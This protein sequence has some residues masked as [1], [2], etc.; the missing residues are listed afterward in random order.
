M[1][2]ALPCIAILGRLGTPQLACLRSWR[3]QGLRCVFLHAD[4]APLPRL[5]QALLGVPCVHLGPLRLDDPAW[6]ARLSAALAQAGVQALTC[7]AEPVSEALWACRAA[8]PAGLRIVSVQPRQAE[9]LAS[10]WRQHGLARAAG[11]QTLAGWY[12]RPQEPVRLPADAFP[13]VVRPDVA[14]R[15]APAFKV[16]VVQDSAALQ[17]LVDGLGPVSEGVVV[18]PLVHGPN[19]LVH[20][21]RSAD[22]RC[23]GHVA[24]RVEV[25]HEGLSVVL[26]PVEADAALLEGCA[27]MAQA[28]ALHGVFHFDFI[29]DPATGRAYFLDLNPRLGGS[30]GKALAAGYDEPLALLATLVP[31]GLPAS[32]FVG[33]ALRGAGGKHQALRA[34]VSVLRGRSTAADY[35][36]PARGRTVA[37]LLRFLLS[38]RDEVLNLAGWRSAL[39]FGGYQLG[40]R[41]ARR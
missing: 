4:A 10:K 28:L 37:A 25:K 26:R 9:A 35:P 40:K 23:A 38:G 17:R 2:P 13:A 19:L 24:F 27:R 39:A 22:G 5:V 14:R 15:T 11:L 1:T 36:C 12:L 8:L 29:E 30:T 7:V 20:A 33:A 16:E 32:A 31:G 18:Q 3:R 34:L 41:L 21:W 6:V